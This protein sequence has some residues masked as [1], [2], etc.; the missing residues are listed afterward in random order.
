LQSAE[1]CAFNRNM[2]SSS[3]TAGQKS[4]ALER[5][6][7][8]AEL[9]TGLKGNTALAKALAGAV[10]PQAIS[11]WVEAPLGRVFEIERATGIT[12]H[13]LRPDFFGEKAGAAS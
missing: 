11:Q 2:E 3:Y 1:S 5:A 7:R 13:E 8:A 6:K 4:E 9:K 12:R 10:S